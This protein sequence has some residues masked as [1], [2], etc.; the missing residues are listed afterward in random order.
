M[1]FCRQ[2]AI[3]RPTFQRLVLSALLLVAGILQALPFP[4]LAGPAEQL[5][6]WRWSGVERVVVVPDIHGAYQEF[7]ALLRASGVVDASLKWVGGKTHL[8][9]LGDLLDRG[10]E[11]RKVMDL[12]MR[13]QHEAPGHGGRVHV[14]AGNHETMNL[15]G[16]LRYV[17]PAEYAAFTDIETAALRQQAFAGFAERRSEA[18]AESFLRGSVS[19]VERDPE[20]REKFDELYPPGYFGH[21]LGFSPD[22]LYGRW[23]LS[24]PAI[25]VINDTAYVHGGLPAVTASAP[26]DE[27]NRSYHADLK[28]FFDSWTRV[29]D[30]GILAEDSATVNF[31]QARNALRI[32]NPSSC[33]RSERPSCTAERRSATDRQKNLSAE[34]L[35]ALGEL[36]RL[37]NSPMFGPTGPQWYRGSV[38][39]KRIL[40]MPILQ[41]ALAN[42]DAARV[43]VG[44]TPTTDRRAHRIM[45]DKVVMLD[46]GMLASYYRGRPAALIS[47]NGQSQ[48]QYLNPSERVELLGDGGNGNYPFSTAQLLRAL[49]AA[50]IADVQKGWFGSSWEI[51]L[52]YEGIAI[53]A[54]FFP[55]NAQDADIKELA[56]YRLDQLLGF[57]LVP[58]TVTRKIAGE[59][60]V[61]QLAYPG[62]LTESR[63]YRER[64]QPASWCPLPPQQQLLEVFDVLIGDSDRSTSSAGYTQPFWDLKASGHDEAFG[65][66]HDIPDA[67]RTGDWD[68]PS[69]VSG[70][71]LAL[72]ETKL[73]AAL[74][75]LLQA[76]QISALLARR[77]ALLEVMKGRAE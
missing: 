6:P 24:L 53:K 57:D 71:L 25:I 32:A 52:T 4:A 45:D 10:A 67:P 69:T 27:L 56:A 77:D 38:R 29:I 23:L 16:D 35:A 12:L 1:P 68:L 15:L 33:S 47:E 46:T 76:E 49:S 30:S 73:Q 34:N 11:S 13:L 26:I 28:L 64:I 9:S 18:I 20:T 54:V 22:G 60:G 36:V 31:E 72:D 7:T 3:V 41:A 39:C 66:N 50:E 59:A 63:R 51:E 65:P 42:L 61:L 75:Q 14:V 2:D 19:A 55:T 40:E 43:V 37:E 5:G 58:P 70:A 74:G 8:V 48:V 21:R 17:S 44:H 62:L